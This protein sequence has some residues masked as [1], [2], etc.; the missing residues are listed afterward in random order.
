MPITTVLSF[1]VALVLGFR[2][3][4]AYNRWW[5]SS[6]IWG[7][8]VNGSCTLVRQFIVFASANKIFPEARQLSD[9]Q[10]AWRNA[11]KNSLRNLI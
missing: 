5:E 3:S 11:L 10:I 7:G 1:T 2:T 9:Y 8:I 4:S 6:K